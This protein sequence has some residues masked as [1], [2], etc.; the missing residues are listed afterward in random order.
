MKGFVEDCMTR[1]AEWGRRRVAIEAVTPQVDCGRWPLKRIQG[2]R[3]T[4]EVDLFADGHEEVRG[5]LLYR[6]E[7]APDWSQTELE[8]FFN[9]RW[10]ADLRLAG[11]RP[12]SLHDSCLDRLVSN[13][14]ARSGQA[15]RRR[16]RHDRRSV[17]RRAACRRC[18]PPRRR[19]RAGAAPPRRIELSAPSGPTRRG[20]PNSPRC[21]PA[22][23]APP[24]G[25]KSPIVPCW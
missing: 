21:S 25:R 12:L 19:S 17:D 13:L 14:A 3:L 24:S 22:T 4:V 6:H 8:L 7:A 11:N 5:V 20:W 10:R 2:D 1:D 15:D 9:D 16:R 23:K 18:R